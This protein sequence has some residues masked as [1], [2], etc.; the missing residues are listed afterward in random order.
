MN[1]SAVSHRSLFAD[2]YARNDREIVISIHTGKEITAVNLVFAD[3]Y[4]CGIGSNVTWSGQT[5]PMQV[6]REL[7]NKYIFTATVAPEYRRLQYCFEL[8][9]GFEKVI[10]LEDD[11]YTEKQMTKPGLEPRFFCL[12]TLAHDRK[13]SS[14]EG[15]CLVLPLAFPLGPH[16][17]DSHRVLPCVWSE[18]THFFIGSASSLL[19]HCVEAQCSKSAFRESPVS[20]AW[21]LCAIQDDGTFGRYP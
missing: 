10:M 13:A 15:P 11:F 7:K 1:L 21:F 20:P 19:T 3:P 16:H 2:C 17:S 9:S 4:A 5:M 6:S 14:G 8:F 18:V 12:Q